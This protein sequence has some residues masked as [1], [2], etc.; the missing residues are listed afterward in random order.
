MEKLI[1]QLKNGWFILAFIA[2]MAVWY[3]TTNARI[4]AVEAKQLE[5][6]SLKDDVQ[7]IKVDVA[8]VKNNIINQSRDIKDIK[9]ALIK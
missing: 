3:G 8:V 7:Q 2:M 4:S 9:A 1:V 6:A 5:Q